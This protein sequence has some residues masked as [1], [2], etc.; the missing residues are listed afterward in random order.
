L[1]LGLINILLTLPLSIL[2]PGASINMRAFVTGATGFVGTAV[3]KELLSAGHSVLGLAR[4]ESAAEQLKSQGAES[5]RGTIEDLEVLQK[6]ASECD[7][8]V[9]LAFIHDFSIFQRCCEA[10]RTAITALGSALV[11]AGGQ[12]SLVITSGTM[13]LEHGKLGMEDDEP[14]WTSMMGAARGASETV[15]LDFAKKGIRASVVRLPPTVHGPGS[16]GFMGLYTNIAIQKGVV[17]YVGNGE[18]HWCACH[19][20]DAAKL[21]RLAMEKAA[22]RSVYHAVAEQG[23]MVKDVAAAVGK[24]LGIAS[25]SVTEEEAVSDLGWFEFGVKADNVASSEK[26]KDS[27]G[28]NPTCP[29]VIEDVPVIVDFAKSQS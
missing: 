17:A 12:R 29:T 21:Y 8:V 4:S 27:L 23:V 19:R 1:S 16:S 7:A 3:V 28:W 25:V 2:S 22:P 14:D 5:V 24:Q 9:H 11:A 6:A 20:D 13:L 10:D 18:N 26:T 15:C